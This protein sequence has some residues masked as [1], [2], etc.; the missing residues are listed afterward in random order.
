M[1]RHP[2]FRR[3]VS[4][5][6]VMAAAMAAVA[7]CGTPVASPEHLG[8]WS[9]VRQ[10]DTVAVTI[11]VTGTPDHYSAHVESRTKGF[12]YNWHGGQADVD[13]NVV[14]DTITLGYEGTQLTNELDL[15]LGPVSADTMTA[16]FNT[17]DVPTQAVEMKRL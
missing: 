12:S 5:V 14:F 7:A 13:G 6:A 4:V 9:G 10:Y 17:T 16:T 8:Q 3:Y 15:T 1:S 11:A 2:R